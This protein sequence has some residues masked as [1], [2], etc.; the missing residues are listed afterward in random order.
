MDVICVDGRWWPTI[1][2][3]GRDVSTA[4]PEYLQVWQQ[5]K[6]WPVELRHDLAEE[7][8]KSVEADLPAS[9]G[10]WNEAKNARRCELIDKEI[11]GMIGETERRELELLTREMRV[12]RRRVAPIPIEG[13]K[14]LHQRLLEKRR[15]EESL[16]EG[17]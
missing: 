2:R 5:V 13:V 10:P 8:I 17:P 7:I 3:G 14:H 11:Q 6:Q 4:N 1:P 15:Q 9:S 16:G 12:H